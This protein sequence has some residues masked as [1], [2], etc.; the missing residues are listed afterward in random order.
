MPK[1]SYAAQIERKLGELGKNGT[2]NPDEK[3]N[4]GRIL[5][6]IFMWERVRKHAEG[7]VKEKWEELTKEGHLEGLEQLDPGQYDM[8]SSPSFTCTALISQPVNRF[9]ANV[10][11]AAMKKRFRVPEHVTLEMVE[12]AKVPTKSTVTKRV[13]E[14]N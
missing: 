7:M 10:L 2:K 13:I 11:A 4:T 1:I 5:G 8:T 3:H 14:K 9:S 6:E 12:D